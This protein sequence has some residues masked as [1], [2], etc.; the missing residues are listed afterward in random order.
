M[1][2][3]FE[4]ELSDQQAQ[5]VKR[6]ADL[7]DTT[8][9]DFLRQATLNRLEAVNKALRQQADRHRGEQ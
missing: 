3:T 7:S 9:E 2:E 6:A 8:V 1:T 4:L 5:K